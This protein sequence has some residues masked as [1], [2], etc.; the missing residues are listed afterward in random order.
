MKMKMMWLLPMLVLVACATNQYTHGIPNLVQVRLD[1]WRSG[2]P[3]TLEQWQYLY[4]LGI[5]HSVKLDFDTEGPDNLARRAGIEVHPVSIEP[6]T[7]ADGLIDILVDIFE[8]PAADRIAEA[9]Q[10]ILRIRDAHGTEGGWLVHCKNGHDRT[11]LIVGEIRVLVDG[12]DKKK[13]YDEMIARGFHP[14]LLGLLRE[15][16]AFEAPHDGE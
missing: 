15:W 8:R 1:V 5:R 6:R 9:R 14:E 12:W 11:G 3:T 10:L 16:H 7:N 4:D 13:A 2:Q